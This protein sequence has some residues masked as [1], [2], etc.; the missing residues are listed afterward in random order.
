MG[1]ASRLRRR[2][3]RGE[4][5]F[6]SKGYEPRGSGLGQEKRWAAAVEG[7]GLREREE[8]EDWAKDGLLERK[9]EGPGGLAI[10]LD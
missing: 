6:S 1:H 8:E 10:L 4:D 3:Q 5:L 7:D 2:R 9:R